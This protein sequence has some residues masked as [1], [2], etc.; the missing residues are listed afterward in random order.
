MK[1]RTGKASLNESKLQQSLRTGIHATVYEVRRDPTL[2]N[3]D[4]IRDRSK[5]VFPFIG[6]S[7]YKGQWTADQKDGFG[8][9]INPD[10][11][12]YEGEWSNNK[13][14]GRGTLW[15][16][17][18]REYT[19]Q[20]VGDWVDGCMEG[21]GVFYYEKNE[22]YKGEWFN[23]ERSGNG[24]YEYENGDIY[25]GEWKF[26]QLHGL[27]TMNYANG[28]IFEGL[29]VNGKKEGPGLY[30]YAST[31]KVQSIVGFLLLHFAVMII[32]VFN[33]CIKESGMTTNHAV[34]NFVR[35]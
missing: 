20:Y 11:T 24:R 13:T 14:N 17:K 21:Q 27:G 4:V 25:V 28:N 2:K 29:F 1:T 32:I 18:G 23:G 22:I 12:K 16:K 15:V 6:G 31:K 8:I 3:K 5:P 26:N 19:R 7:Q 34:G 30:Y 35:Q 33:R 10:N 9:Q